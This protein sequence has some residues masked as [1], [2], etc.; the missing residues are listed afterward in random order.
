MSEYRLEFRCRSE[1]VER[2]VE[3]AVY[4]CERSRGTCVDV[5]CLWG[6]GVEEGLRAHMYRVKII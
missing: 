5:D 1:G 4:R 3:V 2:M 6:C